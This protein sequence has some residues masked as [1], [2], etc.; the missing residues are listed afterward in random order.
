MSGRKHLRPLYLLAPGV[1]V[2]HRAARPLGRYIPA[3]WGTSG[4]APAVNIQNISMGKCFSINKW[5]LD[6]NKTLTLT[7][8][9]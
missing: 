2:H 6:V 7:C 1:A 3:G 5:Y 8:H 9:A 4:L